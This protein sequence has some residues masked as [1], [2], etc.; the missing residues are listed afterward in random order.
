MIMMKLRLIRIGCKECRSSFDEHQIYY[1][2]QIDIGEFDCS[3]IRFEKGDK[4]TVVFSEK[5]IKGFFDRLYR[6]KTV[7]QGEIN[8]KKRTK[9][10]D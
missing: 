5:Q 7:N 6:W 9:Q 2:G 8:V 10:R 1:K 4:I 3:Q